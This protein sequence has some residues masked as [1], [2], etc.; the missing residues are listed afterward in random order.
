MRLG[1]SVT[2]LLALSARIGTSQDPQPSER[3]HFDVSCGDVAGTASTYFKKHGMFMYQAPGSREAAVYGLGKLWT[4]AADNHISD[5]E[6]YWTYS[7]CKDSEK[8]PFGVWRMRL[9]HYAPRGEMKLIPDGSACSAEFHLSFQTSGA[10]VI[11]ILVL[12]SSWQFENNGRMERAYLDGISAELS[13][14]K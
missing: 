6:V 14:R 10:N 13:R 7:N 11:V 4:D 9:E 2:L 8:V 12:D 3:R 1:I 5:F